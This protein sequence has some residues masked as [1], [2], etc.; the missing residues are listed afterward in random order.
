MAVTSS[1]FLSTP[2]RRLREAR[3]FIRDISFLGGSGGASFQRLHGNY[4][5]SEGRLR[6]LTSR[7]RSLGLFCRLIWKLLLLLDHSDVRFHPDRR[8]RRTYCC[9]SPCFSSFLLEMHHISLDIDELFLALPEERHVFFKN[10][11][12][13]EFAFLLL[14]FGANALQ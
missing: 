8:R 7:A 12:E 2:F 6:V 3:L 11:N 14:E 10:L 1:Y 4:S 13:I 5:L 9:K